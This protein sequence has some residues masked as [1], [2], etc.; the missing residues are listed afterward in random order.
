[1]FTAIYRK[2]SFIAGVKKK[3]RK[4]MGDVAPEF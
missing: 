1:M 3:P 2:F 4:G